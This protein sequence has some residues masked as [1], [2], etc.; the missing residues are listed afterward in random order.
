MKAD[1]RIEKE[2]VQ[3]VESLIIA[4]EDRDPEKVMEWYAAGPD[5]IALGTNLDQFLIDP[6]EI[7][8]AYEIGFQING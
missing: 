4:Y 6:E 2:L 5:V 7:R 8:R 3:V 1:K